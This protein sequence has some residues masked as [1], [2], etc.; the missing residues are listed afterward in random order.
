MKISVQELKERLDRG[1]NIRLVDVRTRPEFHSERV[2]LDTLDHVPLD[3]IETIDAV[4][5]ERVHLICQ[6]GHRSAQAQRRLAA[7]G[8][9]AVSV[10]GGL[11][12]WK[13]AELPVTRTS[14]TF[15]IMRQVQIAAGLLV[16]T[17]TLGSLFVSEDWIWLAVLVGAG[18]T[19][20]GLT[21][22]CG[23]ALLLGRMPWNKAMQRPTRP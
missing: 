10:D 5:G 20:A 17:G 18:L 21:G 16:L 22:F 23:L 6:T 1:E 7:R 3:S 9:D 12:A 2:D 13:A 19:Q 14:G 15:P 4:R 11:N 8:H